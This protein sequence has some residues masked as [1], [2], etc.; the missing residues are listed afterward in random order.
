M[1]TLEERISKCTE[2][3][4]VDLPVQQFMKE[5]LRLPAP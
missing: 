5:S 3:Q 2:E 4:I 1:D